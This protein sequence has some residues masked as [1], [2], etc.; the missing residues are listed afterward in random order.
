M[1][2]KTQLVWDRKRPLT[3]LE[4]HLCKAIIPWLLFEMQSRLQASSPAADLLND[5]AQ[6][7]F[8]LGC[9]AL[10]RFDV[11][12]AE[13]GNWRVNAGS[14]VH[15]IPDDATRLDLDA[16]LEALACHAEYVDGWYSLSD[17]LDRPNPALKSIYDALVACGYMEMMAPEEPLETK[18]ADLPKRSLSTHLKNIGSSI[19]GL[20][21]HPDVTLSKSKPPSY[22]EPAPGPSWEWTPAFLPWLV[23]HHGAKL[24]DLD[25][26]SGDQISAALEAL[27][28]QARKTLMGRLFV[29]E[30]EFARYFLGGWVDG[31]W[32]TAK[33]YDQDNQIPGDHW[34]L[35]L[36]A[37]LYHHLQGWDLTHDH[38]PRSQMF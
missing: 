13:N 36:A 5:R 10:A 28:D 12:I 3:E 4:K 7:K 9:S 18:S 6:S 8:E 38:N 25:P 32:R 1:I 2:S 11:L 15:A 35:G 16:L 17:P 37:G 34:D 23:K 19:A 21:L 26:A 30:S 27:P 33:E 24:T 31:R 22:L 29:V 20:F 14:E